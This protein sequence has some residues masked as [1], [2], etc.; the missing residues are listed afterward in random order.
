MSSIVGRQLKR[1]VSMRI[2][3]PALIAL[4]ALIGST[5]APHLLQAQA[6]KGPVIRSTGTKGRG[7][8]NDPNVKSDSLPGNHVGATIAA[9]PSKGG[10]KTR[11]AM[12]GVLHV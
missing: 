1:L 8:A 5:V 11:G 10:P 12:T 3:R 2:A 6:H 7:A 4:V 9:P